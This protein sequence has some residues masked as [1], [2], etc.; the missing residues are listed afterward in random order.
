MKGKLDENGVLVIQRDE[1]WKQ[2]QCPYRP[3]PCGDECPMFGEPKVQKDGT[4]FLHVCHAFLEFDEFT[5]RMG[6]Y[7]A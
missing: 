7:R 6:K 5:D 1:R 3:K 4:T 2:M